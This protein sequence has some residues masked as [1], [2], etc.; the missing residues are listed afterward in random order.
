[1]RKDNIASST[2]ASDAIKRLKKIIVSHCAQ[3]S[4][5]HKLC[6][7]QGILTN[8][9]LHGRNSFKDDKVNRKLLRIRSYERL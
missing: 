4:L 5:K 2:R 3:Y 6:K 8:N 9:I 7:N 1:M